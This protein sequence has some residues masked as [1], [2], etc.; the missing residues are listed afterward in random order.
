MV[1]FLVSEGANSFTG[2]NKPKT[3]RICLILPHVDRCKSV[4]RSS[5]AASG[6]TGQTPPFGIAYEVNVNAFFTKKKMRVLAERRQMRGALFWTRHVFART[7][8]TLRE[9]FEREELEESRENGHHFFR[10]FK[11]GDASRIIGTAPKIAS[12]LFCFVLFCFVF[13]FFIQ[14]SHRIF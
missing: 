8:R 9:I 3:T 12:V 2:D 11:M 1:H 7:S 13:C 6:N 10:R 4:V 14:P 5:H